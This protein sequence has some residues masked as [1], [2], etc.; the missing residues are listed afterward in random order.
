MTES[1]ADRAYRSAVQQWEGNLVGRKPE[2]ADFDHL[3]IEPDEVPEHRP[4]TGIS[5]VGTDAASTQ[6]DATTR[7]AVN[8]ELTKMQA[9]LRHQ[10]GAV[11]DPPD[12]A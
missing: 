6:L 12:A 5:L 11:P 3:D 10:R 8:A 9:E 2:R 7:T 1:I 4:S